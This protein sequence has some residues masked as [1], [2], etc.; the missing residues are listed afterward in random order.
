METEA[1]RYIFIQQ[2]SGLSKKNFAESLGISKAMGYQISTGLL[3]PSREVM[4]AMRRTYNINLH[5]FLTG[6]GNSG[7]DPDTVEIELLDQLAAAGT[8]R[9]VDAYIEK[10]VFQ[11]PRSLIA[12]YRADKLQ[13][14]FVAGDSMINEKINDGDIAVF[15]PGLKEGNGIYV[16]SA[17]NTLMVKRIDF[18]TKKQTI[19]LISANP[20]YI[21]R[22]FSGHELE[23]V[24][25]AGRVLI[26]IHKV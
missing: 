4:E 24:R 6:I 5:W 2:G 10:R 14:V 25:I 23:D 19:T 21:P 3:K 26:C 1:A 8:G 9:E 11:V 13:A 22:H 7:F 17:G 15:H 12:P 18:D 20:D 16:I